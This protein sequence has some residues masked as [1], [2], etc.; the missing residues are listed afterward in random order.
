VP[1]LVP[2]L[3]LALVALVVQLTVPRRTLSATP[4]RSGD[5]PAPPRC[6]TST[7][8]SSS[9]SMVRPSGMEPSAFTANPSFL[10]FPVAALAILVGIF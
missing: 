9:R 3:I 5:G 8:S 7:R 10:A 6:G 1:V 4:A 2:V